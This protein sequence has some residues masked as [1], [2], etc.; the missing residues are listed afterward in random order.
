MAKLVY[1]LNQSLDGYVDH[2]AAER[3][4]RYGQRHRA[5]QRRCRSAAKYPLDAFRNVAAFINVF[6][7]GILAG[8]EIVIHYGFRWPALVLDERS[9]L[10]LRQALI[11]K[12]RVLVP[13]I[14]L[15]A[16]AFGIAIAIRDAG[17]TGVGFRIA[18]LAALLTASGFQ[19]ILQRLLSTPRGRSLPAV[20]SNGQ[21][22]TLPPSYVQQTCR[23]DSTCVRERHDS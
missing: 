22:A 4:R 15:P 23:V 21:V 9:Q 7:S 11:L 8:V 10:Q 18:S 20:L 6:F 13:A 3:W 12:L 14:F 1:G 19:S 5:R 16:L 17:A 2:R